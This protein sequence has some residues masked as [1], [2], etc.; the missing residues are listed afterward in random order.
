MSLALLSDALLVGID[1]IDEQHHAFMGLCHILAA[2]IAG[3]DAHDLRTAATAVVAHSFDHFDFEERTLRRIGWA[4]YAPDEFAAHV[5][6]HNRLRLRIREMLDRPVITRHVALSLQL[7][8][9]D[10]VVSWDLRYKSFAEYMPQRR[11]A[12]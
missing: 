4:A 2:A 1:E 7:I 12:E 5:D 9:V 8:L 6:E 3:G 11:A 10:H